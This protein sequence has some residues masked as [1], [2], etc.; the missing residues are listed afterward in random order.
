MMYAW[1]ALGGALGSVARYAVSLGTARWLGAGFPWGTLF[2]NV[3]GSFAIGLLAALV[4]ADGRPLL[5]VDA[6]AFLL[7]GALGGFTTFS[8]FSLETLELAR[9]GAHGA[10]A[11]NV[12]LSLVSCLTGVWLGFASAGVLNR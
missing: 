11:L 2:V 6:R 4:A 3:S 12:A 10:A 7:V 1:V 5:G 9:A 8:S